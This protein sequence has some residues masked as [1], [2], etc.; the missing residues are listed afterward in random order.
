MGMTEPQVLDPELQ[1]RLDEATVAAAEAAARKAALDAEKLAREEAVATSPLAQQQA[2]AEARQKIAE[3]QQAAA[4]ARQ[5]EVASFVPNLS[6]V[7]APE[8]KLEGDT[9]LAGSLLAHT[10]LHAAAGRVVAALRPKDGVPKLTAGTAPGTALLVTTEEDLATADAAYVEVVRGMENLAAEAKSLLEPPKR[11]QGFAAA[12]V[13]GALVGALPGFVSLLTRRQTV[14]T[15]SVAVDSAAAVAAVVGSLG[16][17][18]VLLDDFR[19]VLDGEVAKQEGDLREQRSKLVNAKVTLESTRTQLEAQRDVATKALEALEK[20]TPPPTEAQ[21][22]PKR[23]ARDELVTKIATETA[24][25]GSIEALV[26]A[27]DGFLDAIH[28]APDGGGR[29]PFVAAALHEQ[30]RSGQPRITQVL[31]LRAS[32]GSIDQVVDDRRFRADKFSSVGSISVTYWLLDTNT[33]AVV[34][35]G[36]Q[37]GTAQV[38]GK[39]GEAV[40]PTVV[41]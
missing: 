12:P 1:A 22:A 30:I 4:D 29:S 11:G 14:K 41:A 33:S 40:K 19:L 8:T 5:K 32:S 10:A 6:G 26:K 27:I 9:P 17:T 39:V 21:L 7:T 23:S 2:D 13:A 31:F 3:A 18:V 20:T 38:S 36:V 37:V 28:K 15:G 35:A 24:R 34:A 25:S 16:E